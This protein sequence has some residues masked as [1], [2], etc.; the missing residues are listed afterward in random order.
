MA[1]SRQHNTQC[2]AC[3]EVYSSER[4]QLVL[5]CQHDIC[6]LCARQITLNGVVGKCPL[7]RRRYSES[8]ETAQKYAEEMDIETENIKSSKANSAKDKRAYCK[9]HDC[10]FIYWCIQHEELV[11]K[12]CAISIHKSCE[13]LVADRA[14]D[15]IKTSLCKKNDIVLKQSNEILNTITSNNKKRAVQIHALE[16]ISQKINEMLQDMKNHQNATEAL[17]IRINS[18]IT[19]LKENPK[20][21]HTMET[22]TLGIVTT[23]QE[24][25]DGV[26]KEMLSERPKTSLES[27]LL[28]IALAIQV[29]PA[30][31]CVC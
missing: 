20:K 23:F 7:C 12:V 4:P 13:T 18:D 24:T 5:P 10:T 9:T 17:E 11:C 3:C 31:Q 16:K 15:A 30:I 8:E 2:L 21:L 28:D 26:E 27:L 14:C 29:R 6:Q 1:T 19:N 22:Y 25:I